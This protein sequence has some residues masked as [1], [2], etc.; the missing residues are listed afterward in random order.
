MISQPYRIIPPWLKS[1]LIRR[2]KTKKSK[3]KAC[4]FAAVSTTIF[5]RI[6][7]L[8]T[9]KA[10]RDYLKQEYAEDERMKDKPLSIANKVRLLGSELNDS[11]IVEKILVAVPER[12]EATVTTLEN[13]KD[14]SKISLAELLNS[15]QAQEQRRLMRQDVIT[16]GATSKTSWS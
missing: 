9:A 14:L 4:L 12:Y 6:M 13:T 1:K 10:I 5:T 2:K 11:R 16:E 8:K 15:L 7:S 3:D